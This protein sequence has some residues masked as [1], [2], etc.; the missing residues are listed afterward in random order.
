MKKIIGI[1]HPFDIYQ[2]FYVYEDGNKLEIVHTKIRDIPD[3]VFELSRAYDV[4]QVDLSG[5]EHFAKGII[6]QIQEKEKEK[7]KEIAKYNENKLTI[8]CI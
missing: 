5:A 6:K 4:Y 7:E 3:T 8:K 2:T 1:I